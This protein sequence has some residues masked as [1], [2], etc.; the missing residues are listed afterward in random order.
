MWIDPITN[1]TINC[2]DEVKAELNKNKKTMSLG[3]RNLIA[4]ACE[5]FRS[6]VNGFVA[7]QKNKRTRKS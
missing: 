2:T 7:I 6:K 5:I 1:K 3:F 4:D